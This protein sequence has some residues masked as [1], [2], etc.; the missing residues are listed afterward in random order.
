MFLHITVNQ[1]RGRP[2]Y[3]DIISLASL[4]ITQAFHLLLDFG[5]NQVV[6]RDFKIRNSIRI[7][8]GSDN[9]ES[10]NQ[11]PTVFAIVFVFVKFIVFVFVFYSL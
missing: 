10:D 3:Y 6:F 1:L 8:E 11:G 4:K 9:G 2:L 7:T 5:E